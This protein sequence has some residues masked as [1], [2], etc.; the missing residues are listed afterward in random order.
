MNVVLYPR[1]APSDRLRVWIGVFQVTQAP[2]IKWTINQQPTNPGL[3]RAIASVR[4]DD[5]L[6]TATGDSTTAGPK[7]KY[8]VISTD[9]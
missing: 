9:A 1:A 8:L 6:P 2:A 7:P 3:L 5:L 4:P